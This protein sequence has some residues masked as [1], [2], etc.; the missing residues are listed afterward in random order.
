MYGNGGAAG[1]TSIPVSLLGADG[2]A[3]TVDGMRTVPMPMLFN[4][5]TWDR[6]RNNEEVTL[7][8]SAA[9]TA[10]TDSANQT[11]YNAKGLAVF[12]QIT[13]VPTVETVTLTVFGIS[14]VTGSAYTMLQ[15]AAEA[16]VTQR[17]YIVYPGVGVAAGGVSVVAGY[18]LPRTWRIRITHSASGSFT[19][20]VVASYIL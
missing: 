10:T 18:P 19:Y 7:L 6:Y 9:R 20:S 3:N 12:F 1:D 16:A 4:G 5:T 13:A 15:G 11:N 8:A 14:P 2:V 17:L